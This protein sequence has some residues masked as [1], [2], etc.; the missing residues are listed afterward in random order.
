MC[1]PASVCTDGDVRLQGGSLSNKIGRVEVCAR[2][3]WG[4]VCD[5]EWDD[6]DATIVCRQ[7]GYT[8]FSA[9][10]LYNYR[11]YTSSTNSIHRWHGLQPVSIWHKSGGTVFSGQY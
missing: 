1:F 6:T 2:S 9:I 8:G 3:Q 4:L 7:L 5:D 11:Y 10:T